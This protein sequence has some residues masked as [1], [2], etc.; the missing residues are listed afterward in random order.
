MNTTATPGLD[1]ASINDLRRDL[2]AAA[3]T[4]DTVEA[5]V[6]EVAGR[7]L[8]RA[9]PIPARRALTGS[10]EPA[11]TLARLFLLGDTVTSTQVDRAL[12]ACGVAGAIALGL[13]A[14]HGDMV[15]SAVDLHPYRVSDAAGDVDMWF[16]SDLNEVETDAVLR[17][18]HVLG[19]G[20]ASLTLAGFTTRTPRTRVLDLGTGCG[21]QALLAS[22][23]S[24]EV[25]GTDVSRRALQ[26]ARFNAALA[27][28]PVQF[29]HGSLYEPVAGELFDLIVSNPPFVITPGS[30]PLGR[31]EYRDAGLPGD[32]VVRSVLVQSAEHLASGGML[33]MLGNWEHHA[34]ERWS[35]RMAD[36]LSGYDLDVWIVERETQD[37]AEYAE[38]WLRDMGLTRARD[39]DRYTRAYESYLDD[40]SRRGVVAV[41]FG[42]M[43]ACKNGGG[44]R[45]QR[46]EEITGPVQQPLGAHVGDVVSEHYRL[47]LMNDVELLDERYVVA[48]D[49]VEER[50]LTPGE[51]QPAVSRLLQGTG[52]GRVV[53]VSGSLIAPIVGACQGDLSLLQIMDVLAELSQ[54][55][56][57]RLVDALIPTIRGLIADGLLHRARKS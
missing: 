10:D 17:P 15:R 8:H 51:E 34:G 44:Q 47:V 33:Q 1:I 16:A 36:W 57:D 48:S 30:S 39:C 12:P 54:V 43:V 25:I 31:Y 53:D 4:M 9:E 55:S 38:L 19:V 27:D 6:G 56:R 46:F 41:G 11:A 18:D 32:D 24:G 29:R 22:R 52:Y 26:F 14:A 40:F 49:V 28:V 37:P 21:I 5:I 7:A 20:G 35:D 2:R 3:Y 42:Y 23:H 45:W 13:V 50:A